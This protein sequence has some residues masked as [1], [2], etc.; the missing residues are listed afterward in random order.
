MTVTSLD[1]LSVTTLRMLAVDAVEQAKSGHPGLPLG[2]APMAYVLWSRIMR[3]NPTNPQW[4]GRD[5]FILS[6]G[7]G[8]AL[9]YSLLHLFGYD[10]SLEDVKQ[11]RQWHSKTPGHPEYGHTPGV[12]ATTGPLGQGVAMGVG[13]ALAQQKVAE[14]FKDNLD[15]LLDHHVYAIVSDGDL[16]EGVAYE[17]VSLAGHLGLGRLIYLYDDNGITIEGDTGLAFTE[18]V[19]A[20]FAACHWQVLQVADGNDLDAIEQ[21]VQEAKQE[22]RRPSLI[23]VKTRIGYGS[24]KEGKASVHGS[25][26]LGEDMVATRRH[27]QWPEERFHIPQQVRDHLAAVAERGGQQEQAWRGKLA[28]MAR[29]HPR[30]VEL[31]QQRFAGVLPGDW[32]EQLL[33]LS[34]PDKPVATRAASGIALNAIAKGLPALLGG[35][36]D[37]APSNNTWIDNGGERNIHFGIREHAMA[38]I[39]NGMAL[40]GGV[41][42][43]CAT[44]LVFSDYL[45]PAVRL[46]ALMGLRVIYIL[47]HDSIAVGEDGPTH[48]PVE[49]V[50]SLRII[51]NL[52]V[53][54]PADA[55]ETAAAWRVAIERQG[56]TALILSRQNLPVLKSTPS[57]V[58]RGGYILHGGEETPDILL[59]ATGSEVHLAL[60]AATELEKRG[61]KVR[62]VSMPSWELFAQ[63][64]QSYRQQVLPSQ[65]KARLALE[66]GT[67]FGW[68]RWVGEAGAILAVD[69][70]GA[71]A[72]EKRVMSEYGFNLDNA[73][74][75]AESL[76]A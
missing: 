56:P 67:S 25:P 22:S 69:R 45:R 71:S 57:Q 70:F 64:D 36:A 1:T 38:A 52:V 68:H 21:A 32:D 61:R 41:V 7:H 39:C 46:S 2:A 17:A 28:E 24:P 15:A 19:A 10:L 30:Q 47:T 23:M 11:F 43:F 59:L 9:L 53:L 48:Q 27:Y 12:E 20:R 6:A 18:E 72:P 29:S 75:M 16:M 62:V 3:H 49:H 73:V 58:N 31:F 4:V 50:A 65:V 76:L 63:Q 40:Y 8:S 60:A 66:A 51:P 42:P 55:T 33:A 54:R 44:F 37:L 5:R 74:A 26:I 13:M 35:S 14:H 34:Y